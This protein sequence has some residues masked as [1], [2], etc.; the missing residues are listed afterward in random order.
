MIIKIN[1]QQFRNI[2]T[3]ILYCYPIFFSFL[4]H[5][6]GNSA[7]RAI[8]SSFFILLF[9][10]FMMFMEKIIF[11]E[12]WNSHKNDIIICGLFVVL[13]F[14]LTYLF[15]PEYS[16]VLFDNKYGFFTLIFNFYSGTFGYFIIRYNDNPDELIKIIKIGCVIWFLAY[17]WAP[18]QVISYGSW[19][20]VQ[21]NGR[22]SISNYNLGFGYN[23]L[24]SA[25][26]ALYF[27]LVE[28]NKA[29]LAIAFI[30]IVEVLLFGSRGSLICLFIFFV[31]YFYYYINSKKKIVLMG[32]CGLLSGIYI[33]NEN[34]GRSILI[35]VIH[36]LS[37]KGIESRTLN[38]LVDNTILF[39]NGRDYMWND[40]WKMICENF[41][42]GHGM[43]A[44]QNKWGIDW[45]CHNLFLE[46]LLTY[47]FVLGGFLILILFFYISKFVFF[48]KKSSWKDL[49][50]IFISLAMG[51][52][53]FSS[54]FWYSTEYWMVIA[55]IVSWSRKK[56]K[57]K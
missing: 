30:G 40:A 56:G 45:Y 33:I 36:F 48:S 1:K 50:V 29:F 44:F 41:F 2:I 22:V 17:S 32:M 7:D 21:Y 15:H 37:K 57:E 26:P 35:F 31:L 4:K 9:L 46:I 14:L 13:T 54:S 43:M 42:Y 24:R 10:Y 3:L 16:N 53:L 51:N 6:L 5:L 55:I 11:A 38:S 8:F 28:K 49:F 47:G 39:A 52:L 12:K 25:L 27:G 34:F 20:N 23:M 18:L 19:R